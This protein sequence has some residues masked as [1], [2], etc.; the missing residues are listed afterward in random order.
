L[1]A[2]S[3]DFQEKSKELLKAFK[4]I[5]KGILKVDKE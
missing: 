5:E 3:E 1:D 4:N 2:S